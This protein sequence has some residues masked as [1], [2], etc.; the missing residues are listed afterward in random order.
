M[1]R[2]GFLLILLFCTIP[3]CFADEVQK[4]YVVSGYA[5]NKDAKKLGQEPTNYTFDY[6]GIEWQSVNQYAVKCKKKRLA[7]SKMYFKGDAANMTTEQKIA[8]LKNQKAKY[9]KKLAKINKLLPQL[10]AQSQS[11]GVG[12]VFLM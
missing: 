3:L 6:D 1:K 12:E 10:E 9:E 7:D 2:L 8:F 5:I 11:K 4:D